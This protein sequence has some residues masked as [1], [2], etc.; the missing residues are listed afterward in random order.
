MQIHILK[1]EDIPDI[2]DEIE[3]VANWYE[4]GIVTDSGGFVEGDHMLLEGEPEA[5]MRWAGGHEI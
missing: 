5:F 1:T 3:V 2:T 4:V